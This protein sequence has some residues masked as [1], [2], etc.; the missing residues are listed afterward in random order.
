[1][2]VFDALERGV[3]FT[4]TRLVTLTIILVFC[5]PLAI[6]G[7]VYYHFFGLGSHVS[8]EDIYD[9]LHPQSSLPYPKAASKIESP[10][11]SVQVNLPDSLQPYF[12]T[13]EAQQDLRDHLAGLNSEDQ[14]SYLD[15]LS[16]VVRGARYSSEDIPQVIQQYFQDKDRRIGRTASDAAILWGSRISLAIFTVLTLILVAIASLILVLLAIERNTRQ[17]QTSRL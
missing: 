9:E 17:L 11:T 12:G 14:R 2:R 15:N 5:L 13:P 1:M 10:Q 4:L 3:L 16:E 7:I 8:Y 6:S